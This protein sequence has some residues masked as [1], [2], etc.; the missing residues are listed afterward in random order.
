MANPIKYPINY[1]LG[2]NQVQGFPRVQYAKIVEMIDSINKITSGT[3]TLTDV[4]LGD[5]TAALPSL[6]FASDLNTGLY[7]IGSDNIGLTLGGTKSVDFGVNLTAFT[8]A[9]TASTSISAG[10]VF[11]GAAGAVGAP[12]YSFTAQT[13]M[14]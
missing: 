6:T 1:A 10:T 12:E 2:S 3:I 11:L 13:D 9:I 8:G 14:G 7:R 5:G 4:E